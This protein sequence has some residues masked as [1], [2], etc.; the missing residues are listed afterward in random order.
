MTSTGCQYFV[1]KLQNT[2]QPFQVLVDLE[3]YVVIKLRFLP[4]NFA[5]PRGLEPRTS[6]LE[7]DVLPTKL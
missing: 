1:R 4:S 5:G 2:S 6:V 3:N 7:T